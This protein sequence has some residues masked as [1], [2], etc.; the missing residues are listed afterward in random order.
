MPGDP[1]VSLGRDGHC[2]GVNKC[3]INTKLLCSGDRCVK[4]KENHADSCLVLDQI[5][6]GPV[7][8]GAPATSGGV[9]NLFCGPGSAVTEKRLLGPSLCP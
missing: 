2:V 8:Q 4:F 3:Q 7:T 6:G 1:G 9:A 5:Q